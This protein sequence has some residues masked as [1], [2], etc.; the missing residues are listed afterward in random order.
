MQT[1]PA[2]APYVLTPEESEND[3]E[4]KPAPGSNALR[5]ID[6]HFSRVYGAEEWRR[7]V[8]EA[9]QEDAEADLG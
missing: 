5:I 7:M 1:L 3:L 8:E 6:A 2:A 4:W 9:R